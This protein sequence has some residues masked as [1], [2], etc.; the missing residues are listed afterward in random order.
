MKGDLIGRIVTDGGIV[1]S[2]WEARG[3]PLLR[4]VG[5]GAGGALGRVGCKVVVAAVGEE[6]I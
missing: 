1:C 3:C 4:I 5:A 6:V 2:R